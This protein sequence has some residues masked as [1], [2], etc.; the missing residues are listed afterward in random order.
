MTK[1]IFLINYSITSLFVDL[2]IQHGALSLVCFPLLRLKQ[3]LQVPHMIQRVKEALGETQ[4]VQWIF[5]DKGQVAH[6]CSP[7]Y[8]GFSGKK[9]SVL[10]ESRQ[11]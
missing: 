5:T 11:C 9:G 7:C 6:I 8:A 4:K 1:Y 3:T 10:C 2:G